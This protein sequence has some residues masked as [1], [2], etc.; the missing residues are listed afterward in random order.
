MNHPQP[1]CD[2]ELVPIDLP[3]EL[4]AVKA[5][6]V[7][8]LPATMTSWCAD[9]SERLQVAPDFVGVTIM[10]ALGTVIGRK[11]A[12]RP[13]EKTDWQE[14][15]NQWALVIGRPGVLKSP[16]MEEALKPIR[17]LESKQH[18]TY[19]AEQRQYAQEK[20]AAEFRLDAAKAEAK[21]T[22]KGNP[23][24]NI[25]KLMEIDQPMEPVLKRYLTSDSTVEALAVL[26]QQNPNGI[27]VYRDE[28][29]SLLKTLDRDERAADRGFYLTG[30]NGNSKYTTD[31]IGRGF[32]QHID[33]MCISMI[34]STQP[35]RIGEYVRAA[36]KGGPGDDGLI[37]RFGLMVWPDQA[38]IF[39]NVDR[40]PD[41]RARDAVI[42]VFERLDLLTPEDVDA[43]FDEYSKTWFL[44]FD[45]EALEL[46]TDFRHGL[47]RKIRDPETHP[48]IEAHIAKYRKLV[49]SIA[50]IDH[51]STLQAGPVR[52]ESVMKAI[53][54]SAYLES[55]A[56]RI[57]GS[58][59]RS[60]IS[61][62]KELLK[63]IPNAYG[64]APFT[65]REVKRRHWS[66]LDCDAVDAGLDLL[67]EYQWIIDLEQDRGIGRPT[68]I[69]QLNPLALGSLNNQIASR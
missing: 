24:A 9:I 18:E 26:L 51:L 21:K 67:V 10:A 50:L 60:R 11:I 23:L 63:K 61:A 31:R 49:P 43:E 22:L 14:V 45:E 8:L 42:Q 62:A 56:R 39:K 36:V 47:E 35:G 27:C 3:S 34:G 55:H 5:L 28:M 38:E 44:R 46:F 4:L 33:G 54:W 48:A 32:H 37:Q 16:A 69:Y 52:F 13:Q 2:H 1:D 25:T 57:Y 30:W 66:G 65:A 53:E 58:G 20:M 40:A 7:R 15:A 19:E 6:D 68:V 64:S 12:I 59:S 41:Y 29:V 17:Y